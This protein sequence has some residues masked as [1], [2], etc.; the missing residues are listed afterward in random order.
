MANGHERTRE[1]TTSNGLWGDRGGNGENLI[2][3]GSER[4]EGTLGRRGSTPFLR[5]SER[6]V[7][8]GN[9]RRERSENKMGH[10][11]K[12]GAKRVLISRGVSGH[13]RV[14]QVGSK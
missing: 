1:K 2:R 5:G 3:A 14:C 7:L 6:I 8:H 11:K 13:K 10:G 4:R 9:S 12:R